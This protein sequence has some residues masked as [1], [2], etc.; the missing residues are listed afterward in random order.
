MKLSLKNEKGFLTK[1]IE[2]SRKENQKIFNEAGMRMRETE[3]AIENFRKRIIEDFK[4]PKSKIGIESDEKMFT[5]PHCGDHNGFWFDRTVTLDSKGIEIEGMA[6]RCNKCGKNI[7]RSVEYYF[8]PIKH[9]KDKTRWSLLPMEQLEEVVKVLMYNADKYDTFNWQKVVLAD[10]DRYV[11]ELYRHM[12]DYV[13]GLKTDEESN[14]SHLAHA[15]CCIL[16]L[17]WGEDEKRL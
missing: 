13:V 2:R 7:H 12:K 4:I 17:M 1:A 11:D 8:H 16:F 5:C 15:V 14:L 6:N 9:D 3:E 10:S